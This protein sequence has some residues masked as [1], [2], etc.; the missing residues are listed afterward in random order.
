MSGLLER[1]NGKFFAIKRELF[2]GQHS[3]PRWATQQNKIEYL[4]KAML[5]G[6]WSDSDQEVI[7]EFL[8]PIPYNN[9]ILYLTQLI[10]SEDPF[11]IQYSGSDSN[12]AYRIT[13]PDEA[14]SCL[15]DKIPNTWLNEFEKLCTLI[16]PYDSNSDGRIYSDAQD[17]SY[18]YS[19]R[20]P[21][22]SRALR[23][24]LSNN[25]L[26]LKE[27]YKGNA[28][29]DVQIRR[30]VDS[31]M[32]SITDI[33]GWCYFS[34]YA[35]ILMEASP[36]LILH[37][38]EQEIKLGQ[39]SP[40]LQLFERRLFVGMNE[41]YGYIYIL[42]SLEVLFS[43]KNHIFRSIYCLCSLVD[44]DLKLLTGNSPND[45]LRHVF[46]AWCH[47]SV[48]DVTQ[49]KEVAKRVIV[50]YKNGWDIIAKELPDSTSS[51][52]FGTRQKPRAD[53]LREKI[54][55]KHPEMTELFTYYTELC[56]EHARDDIDR[57]MILLDNRETF[58]FA[59]KASICKLKTIIPDLTDKNRKR[60]QNELRVLLSRN[61][62]F[63]FSN[64]ALPEEILEPINVL[65][66]EIEFKDPIFEFTH[67]FKEYVGTDALEVNP[68]VWDENDEG[69]YRVNAER[70][71]GL[72]RSEMERLK[73]SGIVLS[74][75]IEMADL[76]GDMRLFGRIISEVYTPEGYDE[77]IFILLLKS[78]TELHLFRYYIEETYELHD[79]NP[80]IVLSALQSARVHNCDSDV[81]VT[82]A[83]IDYHV[84][85]AHDIHEFLTQQEIEIFWETLS[86][87][88]LYRAEGKDIQAL[89][90]KSLEYNNGAL[91]WKSFEKI[92][93]EL[94]PLQSLELF[95]KAL[96]QRIKPQSQFRAF[97]E[98]QF[99]K[100]R[101]QLD[102]AQYK[103]RIAQMELY[104]LE[105]HAI[106][107][108][109]CFYDLITE[110]SGVY[111]HFI[112]VLYMHEGGVEPNRNEDEISK[113][114]YLFSA[115]K[116]CPGA[117][118]GTV[119]ENVLYRWVDQFK[120]LLGAQ[121]QSSLVNPLL[122]RLLA[123]SPIG[124][125]GYE[126]HEAVRSLIEEIDH[127]DLLQ[128]F[129][130][131]RMN[132]RGFYTITGGKGEKM[133]AKQFQRNAEELNLD[134]PRTASIYFSLAKHYD[135]SAADRRV[136]AE[137]I[138]Y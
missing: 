110:D 81:I 49:I 62:K 24:G 124:D 6:S 27:H 17:I 123:H 50:S 23:E 42:S 96:E 21:K 63:R 61:R 107:N 45:S 104:F 88:W 47:D 8:D 16:L 114:S 25:L 29:V 22:C 132:M 69:Y 39:S 113:I 68:P 56:I 14:W 121:Q 100:F 98:E 70:V 92:Q 19:R 75:F 3:K 36:E 18:H 117:R 74:R 83:Q 99:K 78:R 128:S 91:F 89:L 105:A 72:V 2:K 67:L 55:I 118:N 52:V 1:T 115:L 31:V 135:S 95:E 28:V 60:I 66:D 10:D 73:N 134:Y 5:L 125:D 59:G 116:F 85:D 126:P 40:L 87:Q 133:L 43:F 111:A 136:E 127:D 38:Y 57:W 15:K 54:E 130:I 138:I 34:S 120:E 51:V 7:K 131:E 11:L 82:L 93:P 112:D 44:L 102:L 137:S 41:Q 35:T 119:D 106:K 80:H 90:D 71:N 94:S 109:T 46:C 129:Q 84:F 103:Q 9:F 77:E 30:I 79:R 58:K 20:E 53:Y 26:L 122:G 108:G 4:L 13:C 33:G 64:R 32:A 48:L 76:T 97:N 86:F 101:E 37:R 12:N 65:Y